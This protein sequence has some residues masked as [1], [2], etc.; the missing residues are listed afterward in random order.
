MLDTYSIRFRFIALMVL[1]VTFGLGA[2][3]AWNQFADGKDRQ[4][5]L[6]AELDNITARLS[7]SLE[8]AAWEFNHAQIRNI[9]DSEMSA[10]SV[11]GI[12]VTYGKARSYGVRKVDGR[13]ESLLAAMPADIVRRFPI[14]MQQGAKRLELGEVSV[15]ATRRLVT[16]SLQRDL[17]RTILQTVLLNAVVMAILYLALELIVLRP[18]DRVRLALA[19]IAAGDADLSL[20]LPEDLTTE[21]RAVSST[22]NT[23]VEKLERLMGGSLDVVHQSIRRIAEGDLDTPTGE[24]ANNPGSVLA[25]LGAM[26]RNLHDMRQAQAS[27]KQAAEEANRAKSDFLANMSHEIR[28]PMNAIIGMS[29]LALKTAGLTPRQRNYLE[30]VNLSAVNL[31]GILNDIL[32]FS[33]IEAGKMTIEAAN[34]QLADV[35][36]HLAGVMLPKADEKGILLRLETDPEV[37]AALVG[38]SLRLGQV[39]MNLVGN[40][41]KFTTAGEVVVRA[42][43]LAEKLAPRNLGRDELMLHMSVRDTGIGMS[44][45]TQ[46]LL[47]EA[48]TQAD[49]STARNYGG[50]GLGLTICKTLAELM[51]G[52]IWAESELDRGSTFHF[53]VRLRANTV[54]GRNAAGASGVLM[55]DT[56][57]LRGLRILLVEDNEINQELA[58]ELLGDAGIEVELANNGLEA[59]ERLAAS[60]YDLVLMDCQMPV[61]DGY[62]ATRLLRQ[63]P[64]FGSLPIVAM[65]ANAMASDVDAALDAGMNDHIAKPLD[66][67]H[68]FVVLLR[69]A[70]RERRAA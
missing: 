39:L 46:Q 49:T 67:A 24:I 2:F 34:F 43:L 69:W 25:R 15:F 51:G 64:R 59:I 63:D 4:R 14:A 56:G 60:H 47:F 3:T 33:K 7:A 61:M 8:V 10:P 9:V 62:A 45:E 37:P 12:L 35:M 42:G 53:S 50:T 28:T 44:T 11:T 31:L 58:S 41:L 52:T 17:L 57:P 32:D 6:D 36:A 20:R 21:F 70:P 65:T 27:A 30:K 18:L 23:Y 19:R 13:R 16:E 22:F 26:R 5:A 68:M 38:D 29:N 48:F 54:E 66:V 55:P 40:A 1:I